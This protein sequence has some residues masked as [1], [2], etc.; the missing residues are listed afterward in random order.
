VRSATWCGAPE[1][2]WRST[3]TSGASPRG[4][5]PCRAAS[6][7]WSARRRARADVDD[8]G[9]EALAGELERRAR[10]RR[11]LVEEVD[12]RLA[13]QGRHLAH[14]TLRHV[15]EDLGRVEEA[16]QLARPSAPR[17]A[18]RCAREKRGPR[19]RGSRHARRGS[20][21]P[22][23]PCTSPRRS[24]HEAPGAQLD[25]HDAL[26]RAARLEGAAHIVGLRWAAL[27]PT[28]STSTA[29]SM[30]RG[31]RSRAG[32]RPRRGWCA[33]VSTSST[34]TTRGPSHREAHAVGPMRGAAGRA[35]RRRGTG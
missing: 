18:S 2:G 27:A 17:S 8:V 11:G 26:A 23:S 7:P 6:R 9:R 19:L 29:S 1:A 16:R 24:A 28:R 30:R 32:R 10:A 34:S 25:Q 3:S 21:R 33:R 5:S 4:S 13:A 14:L 31:G 15:E 22:P 20:S 35:R 12:H